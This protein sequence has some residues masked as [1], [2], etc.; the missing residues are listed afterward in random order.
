[1]T[2][3]IKYCKIFP[4]IGIARL[5]N[6]ETDYFIGPEAPGHGPNPPGGFKDI[7]GKIK[8]QA[9]RFRV[10]AYDDTDTVVAEITSDTKGANVEWSVQLA[11]KKASWYE[12]HGEKK[13]RENDAGG[14]K[15]GLRNLTVSAR[16][17]LEIT[18][19]ARKINGKNQGGAQ[20]AFDDGAFS[21]KSV[22]LGELAT[23]DKGRLL[24]LGG[25]GDSAY[26]PG[27][28]PITS[29]A[30]NDFW[31]D[32]T[33]DGSVTATV[34][35]DGS[36][37][38]VK[39]T[40]WVIVAPPKYAPHISPVVTLYETMAQAAGVDVPKTLSFTN[41]IFPIFSRIADQQWV[42]EEALRGHGPQ[43]PGNFSDPKVIAALKDNSDEGKS[44]RKRIFSRIR[45][46]RL[47]SEEQATY[48]FMPALSGNEGD[49]TEASL[50]PG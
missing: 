44:L 45:D 9:A 5:G 11:N 6:S 27:G 31:Y 17:D 8:R 2:A 47:K 46:P 38:P 15:E 50:I 16:S 29:Y 28:K 40:S 36:Q 39:S 30:N 35:I 49:V 18:P 12:F 37:I 42:N 13:G 3:T 24:V 4:G 41:D 10:Y 48:K 32:D 34:T 1:M 23:D 7:E 43:K 14:P 21:G 22:Y 33:S 19:S 26:A 25:R 20:Y